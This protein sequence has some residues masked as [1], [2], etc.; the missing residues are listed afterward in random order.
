MSS[1][2]GRLD[3]VFTV[4]L[5]NLLLHFSHAAFV[6]AL[7]NSDRRFYPAGTSSIA[8]NGSSIH[9]DSPASLT[10]EQLLTADLEAWKVEHEAHEIQ[11][12]DD[13]PFV[14]CPV[15]AK[16]SREQLNNGEHCFYL[17]LMFYVFFYFYFHSFFLPDFDHLFFPCQLS[18]LIHYHF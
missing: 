12:I 18:C 3:F 11:P 14:S 10:P 16:S 9:P 4:L 8:G 5:A 6:H 17:G 1:A 7:N 13:D 2:N 15:C